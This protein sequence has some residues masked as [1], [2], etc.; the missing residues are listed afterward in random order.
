MI[1]ENFGVLNNVQN[2]LLKVVFRVKIG[3]QWNICEGMFITRPT[4]CMLN[5][6][7]NSSQHTL[8]CAELHARFP[9]NDLLMAFTIYIV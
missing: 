1:K 5:G 3:Y 2:P 6:Q 4:L 9:L 7:T 8:S